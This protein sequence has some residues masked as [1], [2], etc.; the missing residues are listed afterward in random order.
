MS[1]YRYSFTKLMEHTNQIK[2][3]TYKIKQEHFPDIEKAFM[4]FSVF[5]DVLE[6]KSQSLEKSVKMILACEFINH[7]YSAL[8]LTENGLILDAIVCGRSALEV[9]AFHW[10]VCL[11]PENAASEYNQNQLSRPVEIRKR[12]ENLGAD[13]THIKDIYSSDSKFTH[14]SRESERFHF[15]MESNSKG[16]LYIGGKFSPADQKE[17]F[18]YLSILVQLFEKPMMK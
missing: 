12:L 3:E 14:L 10:L 6:K 7:V 13:I 17:M 11:D 5:F 15:R 1:E 4:N 16:L 2:K 9:L 8:I 18:R